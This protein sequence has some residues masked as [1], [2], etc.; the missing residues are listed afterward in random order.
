M[1]DVDLT[2]MDPKLLPRLLT[3]LQRAFHHRI[4]APSRLSEIWKTS[5]GQTTACG[6]PPLLPGQVTVPR[7]ERPGPTG[8]RLGTN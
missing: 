8:A 4:R 7:P 1:A 5:S 3:R 2:P 6:V